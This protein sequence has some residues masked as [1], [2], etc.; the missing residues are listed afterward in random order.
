MGDVCGGDVDEGMAGDGAARGAPGGD[1]DHLAARV[2]VQ[3]RQQF[4]PDESS[5]T[6]EADALAHAHVRAPTACPFKVAGI[7]KAMSTQRLISA[8]S[9]M[10]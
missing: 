4:L 3:Q 2:F 5:G 8:K 6:H 7:A 10:R 1:Q 9:V